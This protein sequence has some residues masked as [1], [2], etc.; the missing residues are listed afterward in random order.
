MSATDRNQKDSHTHSEPHSQGDADAHDEHHGPPPPPEPKTPMW[1]PAVGALLFL[2]VG[3]VWALS[4]P[5]QETQD[6]S[7]N[8]A[9]TATAT[10]PAH[11]AP[12][13]GH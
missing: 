8:P 10:A 7:A 13:G 3:L 9:A 11:G 6:T 12:G 4:T 1:L 5:S 2:T